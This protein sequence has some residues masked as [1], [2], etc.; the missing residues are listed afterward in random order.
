MCHAYIS[1]TQEAEL[2]CRDRDRFIDLLTSAVKSMCKGGMLMNTITRVDGLLGITL[3]SGDVFLVNV[4]EDFY[5]ED[6]RN[7]KD[8]GI[9]CLGN[10][11]L[12]YPTAHHKTGVSSPRYD[13]NFSYS[14]VEAACKE[15]LKRE[16]NGCLDTSD[17]EMINAP[18]EFNTGTSN[19]RNMSDLNSFCHLSHGDH[20]ANANVFKS[21]FRMVE[22]HSVENRQ[23][24]DF[25]NRT[26]GNSKDDVDVADGCDQDFFNDADRGAIKLEC[27]SSEDD[28]PCIDITPKRIELVSSRAQT[29][30]STSRQVLNILMHIGHNE[31]KI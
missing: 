13:N 30:S 19:N 22:C 1:D 9:G 17:L 28:E 7:T 14:H 10:E 25:G 12:G 2:V 6:E 23:S 31:F 15:I 5:N 26:N 3:D 8:E 24:T 11:N 21:D 29:P 16:Q 27:L 20:V 18:A 4:R